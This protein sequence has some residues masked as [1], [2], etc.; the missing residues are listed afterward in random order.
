MKP[1]RADRTLRYLDLGLIV[2]TAPLWVPALCL[3][4]T[5]VLISSGR[6]ILFTQERVGKD[7]STFPMRKFRS[8]RNGNNPLIPDPRRITPIGN[9]LRRSSL[10]ELPQLLN[11]IDGTMSLVGPRPMLPSQQPALSAKQTQRHLVRPGLTGLAQV[12]GRNALTWDERFVYDLDWAQN[13]T[14]T[15]YLSILRRTA[16]TVIGGAGVQGHAAND[17]V[18]ISTTPT[19][20]DLDEI[21][22]ASDRPQDA[23]TPIESLAA[24]DHR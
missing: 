3:L 13:P 8:M 21:L 19:V 20:L 7:G 5:A 1:N 22:L 24:A 11:V 17:R 15:R 16:R 9:V 6:P 18:T 14:P 12:S 23:A 4:G 2:V 10:D